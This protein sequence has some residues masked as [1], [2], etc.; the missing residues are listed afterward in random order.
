MKAGV[1]LV[2]ST[3]SIVGVLFAQ[4]RIEAP[5]DFT[6]ILG[7]PTDRS[8]VAS[9]LS[10]KQI[11]TVIEYGSKAGDYSKKTKPVRVTAQAPVEIRL[12]GLQPDTRYY[13]RAESSTGTSH[14]QR[15]GETNF[16]FGVQ[17]DSH[18]ERLNR[19]YHPDLY[20]RTMANVRRDQPDFYI[21]LGDDF[22]VDQLYN[23]NDLSART[24][25]ALYAN[26]RQ[27]LSL[28]G[29]PLFLVNG[30]HEQAAKHLLDGTPNS[31]PVLAG[32]ARNLFYPLP[33]PDHFYTG[34]AEPVEHLGLRRDYYSWTWGDA[35]FV[36]LD[37]Y[38]HS[39][40]QID[41]GLGGQRRDGQERGNRQEGKKGGR[42]NNKRGEGNRNDDWSATMGNAQYR[43]LKETLERSKAKYKFVFAH[44]VLGTGRGAAEPADLFEWGGRNRN[45]R[46]EFDKGRPGWEMPIHQ[47]FVKHGVTIFFQGTT[48]Y[49][50]DKRRMV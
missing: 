18:P 22:N 16:T 45:G 23:R 42:G 26:Q 49:S 12:D 5:A 38:W 3:A 7:R 11:D 30:N 8:V 1:W 43:W 27:F 17:G 19:M 32:R 36:T 31:V 47:L 39:P 40:V 34:D 15:A 35:L 25:E 9:L 41:A 50:R 37:P 14:T 6:V 44:H 46:W 48:T 24:V 29:V 4:R 13:Y 21:T 33:A 28:G 20:R 10:T 2:F